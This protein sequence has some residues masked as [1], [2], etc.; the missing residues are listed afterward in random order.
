M[1]QVEIYILTGVLSLFIGSFFNVVALRLAKGDSVVYPPSHCPSCRHRLTLLDLIPVF[2]FLFLRGSCR[3]CGAG[4]SAVYPVGELMTAVSFVVVVATFGFT[5]EGLLQLIL[6]S[7]LVIST[8]SDLKYRLVPGSLVYASAA[9]LFLLRLLNFTE[10]YFYL[11][12]GA[13]I[14]LLL[15]LVYLCSRGKFG[16]GD[17]KI[18]A[19]VGLA[20]GLLDVALVLFLSAVYGMV[21]IIPLMLFRV[22][23]RRFE[24]PLVP[25]IWLAVITTYHV[26]YMDIYRWLGM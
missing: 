9:A 21:I 2:S 14:F 1:Q 8:V 12:G 4:I 11:L 26:G 13:G 18:Y 17:V 25:F 24:I 6:V 16:G 15:Y 7:L 22:V 5:R 20:L 10:E 3:Y 19:L 23:D